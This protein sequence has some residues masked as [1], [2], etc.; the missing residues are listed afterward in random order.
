VIAEGPPDAI[1][2]DER[3]IE[4]YLG[5]LGASGGGAAR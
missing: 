2:R 3:V 1:Q 4:A 5:R